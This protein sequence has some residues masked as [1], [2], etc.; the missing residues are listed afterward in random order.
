MLMGLDMDTVIVLDSM[1]KQ[2]NMA[3]YTGDIVPES[4]V[5][6]CIEQAEYL[7]GKFKEWLMVNR[8]D[9]L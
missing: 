1:R 9:F 2:R 5:I 6:D 4:A 3:D 8:P 7:L